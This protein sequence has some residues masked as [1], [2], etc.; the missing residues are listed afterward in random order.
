[1]TASEGAQEA[2]ADIEWMPQWALEGSL[3]RRLA[4]IQR[5]GGA[6]HD[7]WAVGYVNVLD[8]Y[9]TEIRPVHTEHDWPPARPNIPMICRECGERKQP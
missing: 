4:E 8:A 7:Q 2:L 9:L 5:A 3:R 6:A 1:M